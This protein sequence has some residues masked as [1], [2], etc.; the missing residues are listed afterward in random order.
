MII[1]RA[2]ARGRFRDGEVIG[3]IEGRR[4]PGNVPY[5]VD[6]LWEFTR[7][8]DM[9]SRRHALYGSATPEL[10]LQNATAYA[11]DGYVAHRMEFKTPPAVYQLP[12]SDA[13]KHEDI[14]ALQKFLNGRLGSWSG[15]ALGEKLAMAP[16]FL[17]GIARDELKSSMA[18][19][20][21]LREVV[22]E[23]AK[24]ITFWTADQ[25]NVAADGELFFELTDNNTYTLHAV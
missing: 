10:A 4:L 19:N 16:L 22:E 25:A 2:V 14:S 7:P 23:A 9:P 17:P 18:E 24:R 3:R 1:Y 21:L 12:V 20:A 15:A 13:R 11:P 6:N 5:F 8:D